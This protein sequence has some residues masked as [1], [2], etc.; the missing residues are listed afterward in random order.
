MQN[1]SDLLSDTL[2]RPPNTDST[3]RG[4]LLSTSWAEGSPSPAAAFRSAMCNAAKAMV[5]WYASACADRPLKGTPKQCA[6][7]QSAARC[8]KNASCEQFVPQV[9]LVLKVLHKITEPPRYEKQHSKQTYH[10]QTVLH[11]LQQF[12]TH[13]CSMAASGH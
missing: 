12:V 5:E 7:S 9:L 6:A 13:D 8:L 2:K 1:I 10:G 3:V 4:I 11:E